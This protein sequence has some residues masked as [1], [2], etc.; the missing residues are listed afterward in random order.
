MGIE[1]LIL[2]GAPG[3]GKTTLSRG[4]AESLRMSKAPHA[5]ID[6]DDL[7]M[8]YPSPGR[9][10]A[11]Q[12]LKAIWPNFA[13]IP[14]LKVIIP[15]VLANADEAAQLRAAAP[16][17]R[18]IVCE[19]SAP[20]HILKQRVTE[21]E[22]NE[23]WQSRLRDFVDLYHSR[24]DLADIRDFQVITYDRSV[25]EAAREVIQRAGWS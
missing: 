2:H 13:A 1:V 19:L 15:S 23:Y 20:E 14:E 9:D 21:R 8:V 4:I 11:R 25:E 18:F 6:L 24:T 16:G 10:F 7:S 3:S 17:S 5:V 22:P 12:N